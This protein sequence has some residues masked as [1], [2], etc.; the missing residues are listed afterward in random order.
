MATY[1][2]QLVKLKAEKVR[3]AMVSMAELGKIGEALSMLQREGIIAEWQ[4]LQYCKEYVGNHPEIN[5]VLG[6]RG[7]K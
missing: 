3:K 2:E 7:R 4:R 1:Q 6:A 5:E